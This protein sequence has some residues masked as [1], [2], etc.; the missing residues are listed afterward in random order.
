MDKE[1]LSVDILRDMRRRN[2]L[3]I[4]WLIPL[5]LTIAGMFFLMSLFF[6]MLA[7]IVCYVVMALCGV[8][9]MLL[10]ISSIWSLVDRKW[11][12]TV[13]KAKQTRKKQTGLRAF[14][15]KLRYELDEDYAYVLQFEHYG[16]YILPEKVYGF[17]EYNEMTRKE[18]WDATYPDDEF[19][20]LLSKKNRIMAAFHCNNFEYVDRLTQHTFVNGE[21]ERR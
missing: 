8:F 17:S 21:I 15:K 3:D 11:E 10:L 13:V 2:A 20:L 16:E 1:V 5:F 18:L 4:L 7:K 19:Y 12:P 6:S 9:C 14:W